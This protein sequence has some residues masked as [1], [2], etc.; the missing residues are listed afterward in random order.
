MSDKEKVVQ[1]LE[2]NL[3]FSEKSDCEQ[4]GYECRK[5][6]FIS[7]PINLVADALGLINEMD[8]IIRGLM[9]EF[10]DSCSV[11][12]CGGEKDA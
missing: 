2:C 5:A 6:M 7:V 3:N 10:G 8:I 4:C 12:G 1:G 9:G 11:D